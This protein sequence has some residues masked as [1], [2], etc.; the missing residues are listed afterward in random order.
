MKS[1]ISV[2][3]IKSRF[4]MNVYDEEMLIQTFPV[5]IGQHTGDK[6]AVGDKRTPEGTFTVTSI[7]DSSKWTHDFYDGRGIIANAYG[8]WFIRLSTKSTETKSGKIWIGIGIHGTHD[9]VHVGT[10]CTE[11]CIRM[12]NEDLLKL[13][14]IIEVGSIVEIK[15]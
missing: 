12:K 5:G 1:K 7:E 10:L 2:R 14:R 3:I 13:V 15:A 6:E 4:E 9:P 11:G 8:P